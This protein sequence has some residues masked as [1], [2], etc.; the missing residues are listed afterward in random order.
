M[1]N[2]ELLDEIDIY[3][4]QDQQAIAIL[5]RKDQMRELI[6]GTLRKVKLTE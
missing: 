2:K 3:S 4:D 1:I 6:S 5:N